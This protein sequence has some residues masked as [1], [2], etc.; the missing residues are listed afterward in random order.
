[1]DLYISDYNGILL[2]IH[3]LIHIEGKFTINPHVT[4]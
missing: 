2:L 1:M 3:I 4:M